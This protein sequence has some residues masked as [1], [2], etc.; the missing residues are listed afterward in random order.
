MNTDTARLAIKISHS[1]KQN[2]TNKINVAAATSN[3]QRATCSMQHAA[4][5]C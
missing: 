1:A 4:S 2:A 5:A 3:V